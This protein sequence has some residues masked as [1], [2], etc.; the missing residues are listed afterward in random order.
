MLIRREA[1]ADIAAVNALHRA[2]FARTRDDEP[3]EVRLVRRLRADAAW[4]SELSLVAEL[5]TGILAGHVAC[6]LAST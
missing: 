3:P 5:L 6:T 2:A 1:E 4:V